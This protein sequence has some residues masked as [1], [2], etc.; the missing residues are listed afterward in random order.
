MNYIFIDSLNGVNRVGIVENNRLVE[1]HLEEQEKRIVGN[2]YRGRVANVLQGMEAAFVDI[3]ESK[4][5]YLYVKEAL[6]K[7]VLYNGRIYKISEIIK[8]GQEVIVQ[9]I[10]EASGNKGAKLTT[11]IE[12]PGRYLVFTPFSNKINISKKIKS[13]YKM[14]NLKDIGKRIMKDHMGLIFRTAS[15]GVEESVL[16]EEYDILYNIYSKIEKER[17]FLPCPKLLYKEPSLAYQIIRDNYNESIEKIIVNNK[18]IYDNLILTENLYPFKFSDKIELDTEFSIS[19]NT[20]IQLD[21]KVA[22]QREVSLKSG[23][24]I[25]IDETEALTVVDVNTGKFVGTSSLGDTVLKTNIE[26]AEEIARQIRLRDIGG[27]II[28]DFIDMRDKDDVSAVLSIFK[29][30]LQKDKIKTNIIDIT[31]LG[32][33][34]LTRKKIR[35]PLAADFY[36]KC[37]I[38]E[39]R[40]N[41]I[42]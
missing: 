31:K 24:Y 13:S 10:K 25:V 38:C 16:K 22:L 14:E 40:G 32:L 21:L 27:I 36:K 19:Y 12:M 29:K 33:V 15:E 3:G 17:N 41:I 34:E 35:R 23:G 5:A 18:E 2:I 6:P 9:V 4:N 11:H 37:P 42:E 30:Q 20:D 7:D 39:G 28:V 26:A 1:F 8:S